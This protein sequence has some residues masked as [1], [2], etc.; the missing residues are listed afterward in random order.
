M[1]IALAA[2]QHGEN[3]SVKITADQQRQ[4]AKV[5]KGCWRRGISRSKTGAGV[6]EHQRHQENG[7]RASSGRRSGGISG[8]GVA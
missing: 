6:G 1:T 2:R 8:S 5:L 7:R 3:I 4:K